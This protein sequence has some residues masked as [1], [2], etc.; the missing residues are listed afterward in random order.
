MT[1][2]DTVECAEH[3]KARKAFVCKHLVAGSGLGFFDSGASATDPFPD[4]WCSDCE[5][6]RV[7][8]GGNSGD[9]NDR[10]MAFA[11]IKRV[12]SHCYVRIRDQNRRTVNSGDDPGRC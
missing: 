1:P 6:V 2:S 11:S 7:L 8:E 12:C 4:A 5:K 3:G 9:W 10:S